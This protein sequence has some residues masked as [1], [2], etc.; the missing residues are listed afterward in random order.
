LLDEIG[1]CPLPLPAKLLRVLEDKAVRPLGS[2][3]SETV[4]VRVI[5]ATNRDVRRA[6]SEGQ[7]RQELFYR[8]N[9]VDIHLP[10][11]R[12][13]LE[14]L[15]LLIQHFL[16]RSAHASQA[17]R[18]SEEALRRFLHSPW[19]GNVRELENTRERALVLCQ[20][21]EI[22][23]AE[24]PAHVTGSQPQVAGLQAALVRRCTLADLER[25]Y[26]LLALEWTEGK[27]AEAADL[28]RIDRKT[29]YRKLV[30]YGKEV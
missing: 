13:R 2:T 15:P 22:T 19:P 14:E 7:F 23:P 24:L 20:G 27:K 21:E 12:D 1:A 6:V 18:L 25:A 28:L 8:L 5:A 9:V 16:A 11:L 10:P 29:L 26:I 30:E 3:R 4:N 17:R